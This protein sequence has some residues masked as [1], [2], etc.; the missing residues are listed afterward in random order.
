M[1]SRVIHDE[2]GAAIRALLASIPPFDAPLAARAGYQLRKAEV[3]DL[4]AAT[5]AQLFMQG[6]EMAEVARTQARIITRDF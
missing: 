3:L 4:L 6:R 1:S 5:D 2:I